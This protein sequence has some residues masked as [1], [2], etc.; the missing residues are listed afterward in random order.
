MK[1]KRIEVLAVFALVA[2]FFAG[3]TPQKSESGKPV[4]KDIVVAMSS[5]I[6][7]LDPADTTNTLDGGIQRLIM[8]GLFGFDKDMNVINMLATGYMA[9]GNATEYV[10]PLRKG[11][12]FTDSTPWNADAAKSNLDKLADQSL[13]LK[14]NGLFAMIDHTDKIDDYTI[15]VTLKYPFGAFINTLAHP[16]GVMMSPK[17]IAAGESACSS[18]PVG[19]GQYEFVEWKVGQD[20]K[21]KLNK[22]WWGYDTG[23]SGGTPLAASDAGFSTITFKPVTESATRV[24]MI[25][26]GDADMI[27][28]VP[29]ESFSVLDADKN[30]TASQSEGITVNYV[31]MNT[32][33][34]ALKNQKV[35]EAVNMAI[36]RKAY[37][38]VVKNG[39]ASPAS[40]FEAPKV[41]FYKKQAEV[42]Y[43]IEKAKLL[44]AE[45]GYGKGLTL[46][47][48]SPNSSE[49]VKWGEFIQQQL[50]QIGI[51]ANLKPTEQGTISK[52][53][54]DYKGNPAN[55]V[56][57]MYL[58]GWS[59]STG[60]ADWVL[61]A[62]Y[63]KTMVPPHGS[64]Y[65]Y[66]DDP[67]Y[68][69]AIEAGLASADVTVRGSAYEKAQAILW[70]KVPAAAI[71]NS[72]NTWATGKHIQNVALY[73]DGAIYMRDG[74]YIK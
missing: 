18:Q 69:S 52:E 13:G 10:I 23:I 40:S 46:T 47:V 57:D 53:I 64:N 62:L 60:D 48:Y 44:L 7:T 20:V 11:I 43:D 14:R 8:D 24:S 50:A 6:V 25:Q 19:T 68:E 1:K 73:P 71:A 30:V 28:P 51:T 39:L 49:S 33:K 5:D 36:D 21:L 54:N 37:C 63:S 17:Q 38:S 35:R 34:G 41:Q 72:Y 61:R 59:P 55:A 58:R 42:P 56:Y 65:S 45:A 9:N 66:F 74:V 67:E 32:Q 12:S 3:C 70:E 22:N 4:S 16:A 31:Y 2:L 26:S 29:S 27:F 15:K